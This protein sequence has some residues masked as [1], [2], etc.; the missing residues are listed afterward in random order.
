MVQRGHAYLYTDRDLL[1]AVAEM[2]NSSLYG[3]GLPTFDT[4]ITAL[5]TELDHRKQGTE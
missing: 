1:R 3:K 2:E 5:Y 4:D